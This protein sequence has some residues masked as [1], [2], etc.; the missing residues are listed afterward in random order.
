VTEARITNPL[1]GDCYDE[2]LPAGRRGTAVPNGWYSLCKL[3]DG[4]NLGSQRTMLP[5]VHR[6]GEGRDASISLGTHLGRI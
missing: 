6:R 5:V 2:F 3:S 1:A 4:L